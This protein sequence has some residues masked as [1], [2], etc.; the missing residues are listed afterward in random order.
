MR[1]TNEFLATL[2]PVGRQI[3]QVG[4]RNVGRIPFGLQPD[5]NGALR[6]RGMV[7]DRGGAIPASTTTLPPDPL[8]AEALRSLNVTSVS[9]DAAGGTA[10]WFGI[11]TIARTLCANTG[12]VVR[13]VAALNIGTV[14]RGGLLAG[15]DFAVDFEPDGVIGGFGLTKGSGDAAALRFYF[16]VPGV[17][18]TLANSALTDG[19]KF[20]WIVGVNAG[21]TVGYSLLIDLA[22]ASAPV[23]LD[24][25]MFLIPS[26]A[27]PKGLELN[28]S[29][30]PL[31]SGQPASTIRFYLVEGS[32]VVRGLPAWTPAPAVPITARLMVSLSGQS[33]S[34]P[35]SGGSPALSTTQPYDNLR[36]SGTTAVA[37]VETTVETLASGFANQLT[38]LEPGRGVIMDGWGVGST[39]YSGLAQ[40]T[41]PYNTGLTGLTQAR[42]GVTATRPLETFEHG[43]LLW[44]HGETDEVNNVSSATYRSFM[45]ELQADWQADARTALG[46]SRNIPLILTQHACHSRLVRAFAARVPAGQEDAARFN[47]L[48]ILSHPTY[49]IAYNAID[50][51]YTNA[52]HRRNGEYF[53]K[54]VNRVVT[55]GGVWAPLRP[56]SITA[57]N[58]VIVATFIGGDDTSALVFDTTNMREKPHM[59][60]EYVDDQADVPAI[61]SVAL[62]GAREVT[63]TLTRNVGTG[64]RLRYAYSCVPGTDAGPTSLG[65]LGGNLR[66]QDPTVARSGGNPLWNWCVIFDREVTIAATTPSAAPAFANTQS[67]DIPGGTSFLSA[68]EF[69][70]LDGGTA[71]TWSWWQRT[72]TTWPATDQVVMARNSANVRSFDFRL[73]TGSSM[74]F[75]FPSTLASAADYIDIGGWTATTWQHV[76]VVFSAGTVTIYRNGGVVTGTTNG[77]I[78]AALTSGSTQDVEIGASAGANN[79]NANIAHAMI[80]TNRALSGAEVTELHN[81]GVPRD[82]RALS[83]EAPSHYWPLQGTFEDLGTAPTRNLLPY[84]TVTFEGLAP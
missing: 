43:C 58:N 53:A 84:S 65:G 69:A 56:L 7:L 52:G 36:R 12:F 42:T 20:D 4:A 16:G 14:G 22:S 10:G 47:P 81:A 73:R 29:P 1:Y 55:G 33:N 3:L 11:P 67:V 26:R 44:V 74:R 8:A 5:I 21:A 54:V 31:G 46:T 28:A 51:H 59:G 61:A 30:G 66:D 57:T 75:T 80:W 37:L 48:V 64:A 19:R 39:A 50:I 72:N 18:I 63:I 45:D 77:S 32:H 68:R 79:L 82:P 24:E 71:V 41:G 25:R 62:T 49:H 83:F 35:G 6:M 70:S 78:P 40:G 27:N 34:S 17:S 76:A 9:T 13:C 38:A 60:F 23:R 2:Q 15:E